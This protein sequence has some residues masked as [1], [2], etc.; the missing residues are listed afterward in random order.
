MTEPVK[1]RRYASALRK[2]QAART[3]M[4][5]I[6]AAAELFVSEG[7]PRTT[8]KAIADRAGVAPDTVYAVFGS[9]VRVLTA[10]LNARLAPSGEASVMDR[11]ESRAVRDEPDRRRQLHRFAHDMAGVSA[12]IRPVYEV[13]RTAGTVEPEVGQVFAEMERHRLAHMRQL[14][15]WFARRGPLRVSRDRAADILFVLASPDVARMLCD[16]R[17]WSQA[18]HAAWLETMLTCALLPA[19]ADPG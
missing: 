13:L 6:D 15:A 1:R 16:V 7:Y 8:V 3:R 10:V 4:L 11:A 2:E 17:G 9:K 14:A 18:Q 19:G 12:Q 5:I